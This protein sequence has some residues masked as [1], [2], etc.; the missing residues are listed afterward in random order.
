MTRQFRSAF[1]DPELVDDFQSDP[2]LLAIAD[3]IAATQ[4][5]PRRLP[6]SRSRIVAG[7]AASAAVAVAL[8]LTLVL[9]SGGAGIVD[10][11]LAAIGDGPVVHAV[12]EQPTGG[13]LIDLQTRTR[14]PL[15]EQ[16]EVWYDQSRGLLHTLV[17]IDGQLTDDTLETPSGGVSNGGPVY[18]CA[19][20]AQHPLEA[21]KLRISCNANGQNGTVPHTIP[22]PLP[23]LDPALADFVD[24]Y[25]TALQR[26]AAKQVGTGT[27]NGRSVIW[28]QLHLDGGQ[29]ERVAL[30]E[31]TLRPI[32][33]EQD[34][35]GAGSSYDIS[36]I[37]TLSSGNF[38]EPKPSPPQ[39]SAGE[40]SQRDPI[41][42]NQVE[43]IL[44]GAL[45]AGQSVDGLTLTQ[46]TSDQLTTSYPLGSGL[47]PEHGA[48]VQIHYGQGPANYVY[49]Y[50]SAKPEMAYEWG[51]VRGGGPP[52][53]SLYLAGSGLGF[54][55]N[56]GAYITVQASNQQL[57]LDAVHAL[58]PTPRSS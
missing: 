16:I 36:S 32:R 40:V 2:D 7:L 6:R 21:T 17:R 1:H 22:R 12:I 18:D 29:T 24:G 51:F 57:V 11:A 31:Q 54:L 26:G 34:H 19:W 43:T 46:V 13:T 56:Q 44:P 28:L 8:T 25:R 38:V 23:T 3:A 41:P 9:S 50:E 39:P 4:T 58:Q 14:T 37:E 48:G 33:V 47:S 49:L 52:E 10:R 45:W 53:G 55:I 42:F 20:I 15:T 35:N 30:D 5:P 27:I